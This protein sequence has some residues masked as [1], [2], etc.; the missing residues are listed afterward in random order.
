MGA[1][2]RVRGI[3]KGGVSI[4][5]V[6]TT[7]AKGVDELHLSDQEK[8]DSVKDFVKDTLSENSER[9]RARRFIAKA[10]VLSVLFLVFFSIGCYFINADSVAVIIEIV[11][12]Y[13]LDLAFLAVIGFFFGGY[14]L[15][16]KSMSLRK[17]KDPK[18]TT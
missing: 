5:K 7:V 15:S 16:G 10:V 14:Y 6:F 8:A 18:E 1:L 13:K 11:R 3:F 4:D 12:A 2:K 9:S 17:K